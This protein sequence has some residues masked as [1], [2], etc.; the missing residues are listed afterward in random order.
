MNRGV[1]IGSSGP[2][3]PWGVFLLLLLFKKKAI[4]VDLFSLTT[5]FCVD[6]SNIML[7][8]VN[9]ISVPGCVKVQ[10]P[11]ILMQAN[12]FWLS[13]CVPQVPLD[14]GRPPPEPFTDISCGGWDMGNRP[15]KRV[16][17]WAVSQQG[18]V[19]LFLKKKNWAGNVEQLFRCFWSL[20]F[21]LYIKKNIFSKGKKRTNKA[22]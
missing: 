4:S 7:Y 9:F 5:I 18:K 21:S 3:S 12:W 10:R 15:E 22:K 17:L 13:V 8:I 19:G 1:K 2:R 6:L 16:S 14:G 20:F 11:W